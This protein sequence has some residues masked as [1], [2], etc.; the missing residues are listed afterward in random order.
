M[1]TAV[2]SSIFTP[3]HEAL[4]A[5][6]RAFVERELAPYAEEWEE[7]GDFPDW[8]FT[9]LGDAGYLGLA[10]PEEVGGQGGDYISTLVLKEEMARCGSGGVGMAVAVQTDM[11]TPP[12][13]KFGTKEQIDRYLRPAIKG[14]KIA[15]LGITE[16]GAGSDVAN[17]QTLAVRDGS[18]WVING[19]KIFITNGVRA[20]F[21]TLVARTN[22][23]AGHHGFSLF[24][25]PT[26]TPGWTVTKRL[27][28]LG[29]HSSDTAE[30]ALEDVRLPADAL[31]GVDGEG[32]AQIMWELQGER[33][34]GV[35]GSI[36]GSQRLLD[37]CIQYAKDRHAFGKPIG[38]NQAISHR[39]ATMATE[40]E[41]AR[42]MIYDAA[43]KFGNGEYPVKEISMAKLYGG[44]VASRV[45]NEAMQIF[46]GAAYTMDL[47]IQR[48][49]RDSRLIRIGGGTDEVMREVI[50]KLMG[51]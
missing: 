16:P 14:T 32:F 27:D 48:A 30:I 26:D 43:W 13:L 41:A 47:P 33:L 21:C 17:I 36:A 24:L 29:M 38:K 7:A 3:E 31:L 40:I 8:V 18:D 45:A 6:V 51:L 37:A 11:A 34:V 22:K 19:R 10:Y 1:E 42:Q 25:V 49:W 9:K 20:H 35:A 23:P 12:I 44:I 39:L 4:R 15:C 50:S 46:G 5:T 28:K 2:R